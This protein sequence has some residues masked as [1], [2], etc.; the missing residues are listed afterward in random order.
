M[1]LELATFDTPQT[2]TQDIAAATGQIIR[3]L[4]VVATCWAG[5]SVCVLSD[6]GGPDEAYLTRALYLGAGQPLLLRLG[7]TYALSSGR[8]KAIGVTV[9]YQSSAQ[10]LS[11]A[12]WYEL[13]T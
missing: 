6:P 1:A 12:I 9:A 5:A 13:V 11:L 2:G 3:V 10:D 8:G 4:Q 7:R